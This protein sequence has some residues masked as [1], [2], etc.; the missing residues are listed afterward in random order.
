MSA[1]SCAVLP[2]D[3][4]RIDGYGFHGIRNAR[5]IQQKYFYRAVAA[6]IVL[7]GSAC[8]AVVGVMSLKWKVLSL[9]V[10]LWGTSARIVG[11]CILAKDPLVSAR[12]LVQVQDMLILVGSMSAVCIAVL[13]F[14]MA[15]K[16]YWLAFSVGA[17]LGMC[18]AAF[19]MIKEYSKS[20]YVGNLDT[21]CCAYE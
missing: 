20:T 6:N 1:S 17:S 13:F 8:M 19:N 11:D 5:V 3:H 4:R 2:H 7:L 16:K 15:V 21:L 18:R 9:P 14:P 10:L 12:D